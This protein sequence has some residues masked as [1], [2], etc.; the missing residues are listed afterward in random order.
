MNA[1]RRVLE[2]A[3]LLA[4]LATSVAALAV[5]ATTGW[6]IVAESSRDISA[7]APLRLPPPAESAR[8]GDRRVVDIVAQS[9]DSVIV[10]SREGAAWRCDWRLRSA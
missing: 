4:L 1:A 3:G 7:G 6:S 9:G 8:D 10:R 2:R 5:A